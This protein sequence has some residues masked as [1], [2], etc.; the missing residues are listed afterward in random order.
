[1]AKAPLLISLA[2]FG[3]SEVLRLGQLHY[4]RLAR[5]AGADGVEVRAELLRD[6]AAELPEL[7]ATGCVAVYSNPEPLWGAD[8]ALDPAALERGLHV[9]QLLGAER[10]K[11]S[12]GGFDAAGSQGGLQAL[13]C[14][15]ADSP[16]ELVIEN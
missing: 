9:A 13:R 6:P 8:G 3:A 4:T 12:I 15:L 7:A 14:R 10:L 11:M 5:E 2:A 1:M 16:V